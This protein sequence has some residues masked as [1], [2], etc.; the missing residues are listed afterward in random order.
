[1]AEEQKDS[2]GSS[3]FKVTDKRHFNPE[4]EL[5]REGGEEAAPAPEPPPPAGKAGEAPSPAP[6]RP[7]AEPSH[8][9]AGQAALP[10]ADFLQIVEFLF[11]NAA[12]ALGLIPDPAGE[13]R[14]DLAH[15]SHFI[16]L[17]AVLKQK[18]EGRLTAEE[19]AVLQDTLTRLRTIF[20]GI[21]EKGG[22]L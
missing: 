16:D 10:P 4:G 7:S 22:A 8:R 18:T 2:S 14:V 17:I 19:D 21:K 5:V 13:K 20:L 6:E 3:G 11:K 1:M 12:F 9:E 15:A